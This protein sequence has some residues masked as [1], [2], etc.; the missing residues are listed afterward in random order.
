MPGDREFVKTHIFDDKLNQFEKEDESGATQLD[1]SEDGLTT[2][3][4]SS[5]AIVT[6]VSFG[7][8]KA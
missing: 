1:S 5:C 2:L 7:G 3:A 6:T 4:R 8:R